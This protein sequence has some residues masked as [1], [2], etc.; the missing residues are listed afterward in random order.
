MAGP[1][2]AAGAAG[3]QGP[4]GVTGSAG[5]PKRVERY[6]KSTIDST[7]SIAFT[8][9]ACTAAPDVDIITGWV[10]VGLGTS[11]MITGGVVGTPT[12]S[13]ATLAVKISQGTLALSG[14]PFT[15]APSGT[16]LTIRVICN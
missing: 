16:P 2:G 1:V 3:A 12:L 10:N 6:T 13:G 15:T 14:S 11:Q 8:W 4:Q 7:G 5:T 9:P